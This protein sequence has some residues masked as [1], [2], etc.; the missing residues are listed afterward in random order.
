M[1]RDN[2]RRNTQDTEADACSSCL[3]DV[4][5]GRLAEMV[6][7]GRCELPD[8]LPTGDGQRLQANVRGRLRLRLV[9][10]IARAIAQHLHR[11]GGHCSESPNHA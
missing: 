2:A 7:D 8:D 3:T 5:I 4:Q 9:R 10:Y 1:H 11:D 6:A